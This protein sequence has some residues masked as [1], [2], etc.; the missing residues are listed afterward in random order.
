MARVKNLSTLF[1]VPMLF[2]SKYL[3]LFDDNMVDAFFKM[4]GYDE[5]GIYALYRKDETTR[6]REFKVLLETEFSTFDKILPVNDDYEMIKFRVPPEYMT[7]YQLITTGHYSQIPKALKSRILTFH[8][9]DA[10]NE[11]FH[12]LFRTETLERLREKE[13]GLPVGSLKG[14]PE[15]AERFNDTGKE[16]FTDHYLDELTSTVGGVVR[17]T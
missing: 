13:Y 17:H 3:A 11:L 8:N 6:Y 4:R 12:V 10:N 14:V 5:L 16:E 1:F 9:R 2:K 7:S 15:L